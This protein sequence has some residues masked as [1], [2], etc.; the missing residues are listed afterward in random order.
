MHFVV[1]RTTRAPVFSADFH[2]SARRVR[3]ETIFRRCFSH[4]RGDAMF[5]FRVFV[6][7]FLRVCYKV[8]ND[9]NLYSCGT[10]QFGTSRLT[11]DVFRLVSGCANFTACFL[12]IGTIRIVQRVGM[13]GRNGFTTRRTYVLSKIIIARFL[14]FHPM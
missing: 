9:E 10:T 3:F 5:F 14:A 7:R 6:S 8:Y 11:L 4:R 2:A 12:F 13:N 1:S